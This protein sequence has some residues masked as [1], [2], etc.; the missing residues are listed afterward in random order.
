MH[1]RWQQGAGGQRG[2]VVVVDSAGKGSDNVLL[3]V[4]RRE[5]QRIWRREYIDWG[6]G[7]DVLTVPVECT[8]ICMRG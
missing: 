5:G 4:D 6:G 8:V 1:G 7:G 2:G 3:N